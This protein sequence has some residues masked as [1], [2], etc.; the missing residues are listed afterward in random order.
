MIYIAHFQSNVIDV[1]FKTRSARKLNQQCKHIRNLHENMLKHEGFDPRLIM[2]RQRQP[3]SRTWSKA[4]GS[5]QNLSAIE[6]IGKLKVVITR[7]ND[8]K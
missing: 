3:R 4:K 8:K 6:K 5:W 2:K 1:T 7:E